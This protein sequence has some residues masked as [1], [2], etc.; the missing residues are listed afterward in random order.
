MMMWRKGPGCLYPADSSA[1]DALLSLAVGDMVGGDIKRR[2]NIRHHRLYFALLTKVA[3]MQEH[4]PDADAVSAA[5]KVASGHCDWIQTPKGL[6]GLPKSIS[7]AKMDQVQFDAFWQK[8][9]RYCC[10]HVIPGL[11]EQ[12]LR[13]EVLALIADDRHDDQ[14]RAKADTLHAETDTVDPAG[15]AHPD[16]LPTAGNP[17]GS[18][19][20]APDGVAPS[21]PDDAAPGIIDVEAMLRIADKQAALG[22]AAL[23]AWRKA[24]SPEGRAAIRPIRQR[25]EHRAREIDGDMFG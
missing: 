25:L 3:E 7:F 16:T 20:P 24:L 5:F 17:A 6:V 22:T 21:P 23:N 9:L 19:E 12:A 18:R 14:G 15:A 13:D 11:D 2:R 1:E 4:Y 8:A 10:E